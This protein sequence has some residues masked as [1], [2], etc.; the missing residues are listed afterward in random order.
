LS[1]I[2]QTSEEGSNG[3]PIASNL[4]Q[5]TPVQI[6]FYLFFGGVDGWL[7]KV[8]SDFCNSL[9]LFDMRIKEQ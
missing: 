9:T 1:K 8:W 3:L 6:V 5:F 7:A 4:T 2:I